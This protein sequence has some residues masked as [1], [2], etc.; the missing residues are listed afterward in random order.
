MLPPSQ[1]IEFVKKREQL[2]KN[3]EAG[4]VISAFGNPYTTDPILGAY[5][6]TNIRRRDDRASRW[7]RANVYCHDVPPEQLIMFAAF[8]RWNNWP[9]TINEILKA[10]LYPAETIDWPAIR[11][12]LLGLER[13]KMWTGAYMI[14]ASPDGRPKASFVIDTIICESVKNALPE[15]MEALQTKRRR[16]VWQVL[17]SCLHFGSFMAGQVV[18][19]LTWTT[20]L[21]R[22]RDNYLW[23]PQGPGSLRGF[24]R[25][26]GLPLKTRHKEQEWCMQL[27]LWRKEIIAE[28][29]S[30][31][32]D[33]TLHD[34]NNIA[35][36]IDKFLRVK[37]G[38]GRPRSLYRP[39]TAY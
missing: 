28:L 17:N 39:E 36:E 2:R 18:D 15:L 34:L 24:N 22:P 31:Y 12:L 33:V 3:K 9:P 32:N 35:C 26:L 1:L 16:P 4:I 8:C 38:E 37:N 14:R 29:G 5:R 7:L 10:K 20:L 30:E 25:L 13:G 19:D 21:P 6:F 27:R 23:A 11:D